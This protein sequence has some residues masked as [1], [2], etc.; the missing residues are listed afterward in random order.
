MLILTLQLNEKILQEYRFQKSQTVKIGRRNKNDVV[1]NNLG[2]SGRH[3]KIEFKNG[4][5]LYTDLVST[6]GSFINERPVSTH[7]LKNND[8]ITVGKYTLLV[9]MEETAR[10]ED[11]ILGMDQTM[12]MDS[13]TFQAMLSEKDKNVPPQAQENAPGVLSFLTGG[14]GQV[15]LAKRLVK[16]GKSANSDIVTRGLFV[17]QTA[18]TISKRANGYYLSAAGGIAKPRLNGK[19]VKAAARLNDADIIKVGNVKMQFV[20][21]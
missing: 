8:V 7:W 6:N 10:P 3:A 15:A 4:G 21:E 19:A 1:I 13:D 20:G 2:V 17:S 18:A 16:I 12:V 11:D 14:E 5:F 9:S